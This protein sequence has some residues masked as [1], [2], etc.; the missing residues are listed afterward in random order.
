M[1]YLQKKVLIVMF[2]TFL[3]AVAASS[4]M[5]GITLHGITGMFA[6]IFKPARYLSILRSFVTSHPWYNLLH[7]YASVKFLL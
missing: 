2:A 4:T 7:T 1:Y 3:T 6:L 5:M